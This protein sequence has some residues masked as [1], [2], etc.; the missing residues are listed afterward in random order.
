MCFIRE[1]LQEHWFLALNMEVS[2]KMSINQCWELKC[3]T[4]FG[5][6]SYWVPQF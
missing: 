3:L 4:H 5:K 2:C 1:N 6:Y